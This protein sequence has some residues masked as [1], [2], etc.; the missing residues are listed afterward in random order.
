ML[1]WSNKN[2]R[3]SIESVEKKLS[4]ISYPVFSQTSVDGRVFYYWVEYG[5]DYTYT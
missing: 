5:R 2:N 4:L 3:W 1:E